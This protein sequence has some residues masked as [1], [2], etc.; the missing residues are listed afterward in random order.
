MP[1]VARLYTL[2]LAICWKS[3]VLPQKLGIAATFLEE[4]ENRVQEGGCRGG[5]R[6]GGADYAPASRRTELPCEELSLS[7][8]GPQR[9]QDAR[10][11]GQDVANRGAAT[12]SVPRLPSATLLHSS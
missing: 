3:R 2:M 7:R 4:F 8:L 6:R 10:F 11:S 5:D 9:R 1:P 12:G